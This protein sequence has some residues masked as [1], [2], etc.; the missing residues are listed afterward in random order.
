M[1]IL[2]EQ[3]LSCEGQW[4]ESSLLVQLKS[5]VRHR[6]KGS[7][8]WYTLAELAIKFGSQSCAEKIKA[9]KMGDPILCKSQVREHPDAPGEPE[10]YWHIRLFLEH[11]FFGISH[12]FKT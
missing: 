8:R 5:E 1:Q 9:A 2:Y 11:H 12:L 7:R 4:K 6:K 10:P 3:W